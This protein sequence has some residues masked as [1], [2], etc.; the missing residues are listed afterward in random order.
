MLVVVESSEMCFLFSVDW[1]T[2]LTTFIS[3]GFPSNKEANRKERGE[4]N[5]ILRSQLK[6]SW[7]G[8]CC[9]V[10]IKDMLSLC[11]LTAPLYTTCIAYFF[12]YHNI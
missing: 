11:P 5:S 2:T 6:R 3:M 8:V 1:L 12:D 9:D 10:E 7:G 4:M